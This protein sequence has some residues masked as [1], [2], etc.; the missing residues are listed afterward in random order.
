MINLNTKEKHDFLQEDAAD[1]SNE[2]AESHD[3]DLDGTGDAL[4][5]E[6]EVSTEPKEVVSDEDTDTETLDDTNQGPALE[7]STET[8][9]EPELELSEE[10]T[11][12]AVE[13]HTEVTPTEEVD[14][15]ATETLRPRRT[16]NQPAWMRSGEFA[17]SQQSDWL[18][19]AEFLKGL[20][21]SGMFSS[22]EAE[23][24]KALVKIVTEN[25]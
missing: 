22:S 11:E 3:E 23:I 16:R 21:A 8:T 25:L 14:E 10:T 6:N 20:V 2:F 19:R 24:G 4:L 7:V 17:M 1:A 5:P 12:P 13:P 15:D 9:T 18:K